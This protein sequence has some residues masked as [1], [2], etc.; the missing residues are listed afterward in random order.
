MALGV[1][2]LFSSCGSDNAP[3]KPGDDGFKLKFTVSMASPQPGVRSEADPFD[4]MDWGDDYTGEDGND[5]DNK[6][7]T[8]VPMI[9]P[10]DASTGEV[11]Y[12]YP[13]GTITGVTKTLRNGTTD[14]YDVTCTF[15]SLYDLETL[16]KGNYRI[17]V[18]ANVPENSTFTNPGAIEFQHVGKAGAG[19]FT[20]IPMWGA[21][22]I[23]FADLKKDVVNNVGEIPV[24]RAMAQIRV[25]I[26][27]A[28]AAGERKVELRS[29]TVHSLSDKGYLCPNGW[30]KLAT[31]TALPFN[32]TLR[33]FSYN[34]EAD[35]VDAVSAADKKTLSFYLPEVANE[36]MLADISREVFIRVAYRADGETVDN[37]EHF[38]DLYLCKY[39]NGAPVEDAERWDVVRNHIYEYNITGIKA[40]YSLNAQLCIRKWAY[41]KIQSEI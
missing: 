34:K 5:F 29:I 15:N 39:E 6:I 16:K 27:D 38:G 2:L 24:L 11:N 1:A 10:Y 4:G 31:V 12:R 32:T 23:S 35:H 36:K 13:A 18:F 30:E 7:N 26:A 22:N 33:A 14:T 19:N 21:L 3:D 20:Q 17:M 25:N 40:D 28:L 41:R 9:Y 8:L 37:P